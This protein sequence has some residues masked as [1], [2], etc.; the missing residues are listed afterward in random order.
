MRAT[1]EDARV[2]APFRGQED[3]SMESCV[4]ANGQPIAVGDQTRILSIPQ[5]L[6]NDLPEEDVTRLR[7]QEGKVM[8]VLDV[9]AHG[10][11]WFGTDSTG[12]WFCLR[13]SGVLVVQS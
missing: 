9:D 1:C 5:W 3:V 4:D 11:V 6:T 13:P 2:M 10:Y 12:R 8:R 7:T